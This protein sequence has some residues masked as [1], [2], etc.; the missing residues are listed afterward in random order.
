MDTMRKQFYDVERTKA[1]LRASIRMHVREAEEKYELAMS[2][3]QTLIEIENGTFEI[4]LDPL[5]AYEV[6]KDVI[7]RNI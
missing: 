1:N 6:Y 4:N 3:I 5:G 7:N 2:K